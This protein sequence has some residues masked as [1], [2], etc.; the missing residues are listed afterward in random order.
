VSFPGYEWFIDYYQTSDV[1]HEMRRDLAQRIETRGSSELTIDAHKKAVERFEAATKT[2]IELSVHSWETTRAFAKAEACKGPLTLY[3]Q[4]WFW[5][6][7]SN[8][9]KPE[10]VDYLDTD[11]HDMWCDICKLK[12]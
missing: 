5:N 7:I 8:T 2:Y 9:R 10:L 12:D 3:Q 4:P 1:K 6:L 11:I